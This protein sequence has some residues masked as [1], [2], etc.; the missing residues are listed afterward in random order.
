MN[1]HK[2]KLSDR[3]LL[4]LMAVLLVVNL[5]PIALYASETEE[6]P[7]VEEGNDTE[8]TPPEPV[9]ET[10]TVTVKSTGSGRIK[11]NGV[12][13]ESLTVD[14]NAEITVEIVPV[15]MESHKTYI[16]SLMINGEAQ[17]VE[18][19]ASYMDSAYLVTED[20]EIEVVFTTEYSI[21]GLCG[22]GGKVLFDSQPLTEE[23]S[24]LVVDEGATVN[25]QVLP[26]EQYQIKSVKINGIE[27]LISDVSSFTKDITISQDTLVEA[28]FE[29]VYTLTITCDGTNGTIDT[30]PSC[31][32]GSVKVVEGSE[33]S[34]IATPNANYRVS[35]VV[36]NGEEQLLDRADLTE[37]T[38]NDYA[39]S[40][41]S[42]TSMDQDYTYEIEFALNYYHVSVQGSENGNVSFGASE[43]I[44]NVEV[45][46]G[47]SLAVVMAPED[48]YRIK[49]ILI[50]NMEAPQGVEVDLENDENYVENPDHTSN[51]IM[52]DITQ[53]CQIEVEFEKMDQGD[54]N[55]ETYLAMK[56]NSGELKNH[57]IDDTGNEVY[58]YSKDSEISL[59][60]VTPYNQIR[61]KFE[62]EES[63][64]NWADSGIV[65][66]SCEITAFQVRTGKK[67]NAAFALGEKKIIFILD[68]GVP[69]LSLIPEEPHKNDYYNK[70][71]TVDI[72]AWDMLE[73]SVHSGIAR[74]EYQVVCGSSLEDME[75]NRTQN[76]I[77]YQGEEGKKGIE[78]Y[79]KDAYESY[80]PIIIDSNVNNSDFVRLSVTVTD[81][82]GNFVTKTEDFKINTTI[83][84][85]KVEMS[86]TAN[87]EAKDGFYTSRTATITV[88]D[89]ASTF[90]PQAIL[91][92][93]EIA[94]KN[95]E[96]DEVIINKTAMLS[97]WEV[98]DGEGQEHSYTSTL[99]FGT[100]ANYQWS[101]HYENKAGNRVDGIEN[102]NTMI[103]TVGE[104]VW[105]F[106]VDTK[107]PKEEK[108]SI[109]LE[110]S[111]WNKLLSA[112]T[113]GVFAN[114]SVSALAVS[115]DDISPIE[116][117]DIK[118]YKSNEYRALTATELEELYT[119]GEFSQDVI[120]VDSDE[121]FVIY[122]RIMDAA[123]NV[124]YV[125]TDGVVVDLTE[126]L[127]E[128]TQGEANQNGFYNSDVEFGIFVN[129]KIVTD[130]KFSGI[131]KV[132][133]V[134]TC[135]GKVTHRE[136]LYTFQDE[137]PEKT[138]KKTG[139]VILD[140]DTGLPETFQDTILVD[141]KEN[142]GD[143]VQVTVMVEDHAGN[144]SVKESGFFSICSTKPTCTITFEDKA[145][146]LEENYGWYGQ[147]RTATVVITDRESV[148]DQEAATEGLVISGENARGES[149]KL[150]K[151]EI[152]WSTDPK[153]S[154]RHIATVIFADNAKYQWSISYTN[155]AD[156]GFTWE[157]AKKI[158]ESVQA[159]TVDQD[160]PSGRV[161]VGVNLWDKILNKLTFGLYSKKTVDVRAEAE[162]ETSPV[163][164]QYYKT[165][166]PLAM[167]EKELDQQKFKDYQDFSV[168]SPEQFVVYL[169][170]S[171]YAGNYVY[172]NSDGIIVD[173]EASHITLTREEPNENNIYNKDVMV[174]VKVQEPNPYA[175]IKTIEYW[176]EADGKE[177]Q[178]QTLYSFD[179]VR[180]AGNNS[181]GGTL[182]ITDW[183]T[184]K[185]TKS[186]FEGEVPTQS[187]LKRE[188]N[189]NI[190]VNSKKNNSS[191]V[192]VYVR[193]EDNA[194]N[195]GTDSVKLDIDITRPEIK[196]SYDNNA[197]NNGNG[198]FP[199]N[200]TATVEIKKRTN[201]FNEEK[202][203]KGILITAVD[204]NGKA[205]D[206]GEMI[207]AWKTTEGTTPDDAIHK[208]TI[209]YYADAN[210][211]FA[212]SYRDQA[213]NVNKKVNTGTSVAPYQFTVDKNAPT[214]TITSKTA[215]GRSD[216]FR[217]LVGRLTF[218][219]WSKSEI[220]VSASAED[221]TSPIASVQYYKTSD[222]EAITKKEL[223]E[224]T[225]WKNFKPFS[226]KSD[227]Q[228]TI[229]LKIMDKAG[230]TS[231]IS[232]NG[233]IVDRT[234]PRTESIA[235]EV[236]ISPEQPVNGI[237]SGNVGV[238]IKV[239]DPQVHG[240]YSGLKTISY[241]VL[242]MGN[243]TQS[244]VLYQ[245]DKTAPK[246][247][248]LRKDWSG[249]IT[250]DST[251]NNSNDVVIEVF[252]EDNAKNSSTNT[253]SIKIDITK[254]EITV[255]YDNNSPD[256]EKYYKDARTA[257]I[258]V[259]E[260]NFDPKDIC[261]YHQYRWSST[262]YQQL[263][264]WNRRWKPGQHSP[265]S[266]NHL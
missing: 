6:P 227:Q 100:D 38:A 121:A 246:Q 15:D 137:E 241:R 49:S 53:D 266:N 35:R 153:D 142:D 253:E 214:G 127:V 102:G 202:A 200:R 138:V 25:V 228:L 19:Y 70:D 5:L 85:V 11:L 186:E 242:N 163:R 13:Q 207:S 45:D 257:T 140:S 243:E 33:I 113:F 16:S 141:S 73:G 158:G 221:I 193:T 235:P 32:G 150:D 252:A 107:A 58:V 114:Y 90:D 18:K 12:E 195:V 126:A 42:V 31:E 83:P 87:E 10:N 71:F 79:S 249:S 187:Q 57:Y 238:Q 65:K 88:T 160:A 164:I 82:S 178:R 218:G 182:T 247:S 201:H 64:G 47:S 255:R 196:V 205:V 151:T 136:N 111:V 61:L 236:S 8:E 143:H 106:T 75:N 129:E 189:G 146:Y 260:R 28:E 239:Q 131:K 69:E 41:S 108:T 190:V 1:R 174:T 101:L 254:P 54:N 112:L 211:T 134:V 133:Y 95:F 162:D 3:I 51:Y 225:E 46:H 169:K 181:N 29:K 223:N 155:K 179:Y 130:K 206:A 84:K 159:F 66:G 180:D 30:T 86:G 152:S 109:T 62:G 26:E 81:W 210:Y 92:G 21:S 116:A 173:Q 215:E 43:S 226:I 96:G 258:V 229:Y 105:G 154:N 135:D 59:E 139:E 233:M 192:I 183:A 68:H 168:T 76:G 94:A 97:E 208:A 199:A 177:T 89:R 176:V 103:E 165:G 52:R 188:W 237:Y 172:I 250:V 39:Y 119:S 161:T 56:V 55:F 44:T 72:E 197:D 244:G 194:G 2:R 36:K 217:R 185:E 262:I 232:T 147:V 149:L 123:G 191:D 120:S 115:T 209:S 99:D 184:G 17:V 4:V 60:P 77:L 67:Q 245:F 166:N 128:L 256:S 222:A 125:S 98:K 80:Q 148:F 212:I 240:A 144:R 230:N 110:T 157:E 93:L 34:V 117:E 63:Y 104:H 132:D 167:D 261:L 219:I 9:V 22:V 204:A 251:L 203:N 263:D 156:L 37:K 175:G 171:D 213:G 234:D 224:I 50:K 118:Y 124:L 198:Y 91:E 40:D 231:Y 264:H 20:T 14:Q 23:N 122:A 24:S 170:I 27:E 7:I 220:T 216:S 78:K 74:V 259:N 145:N 48:T 248:E 265:H